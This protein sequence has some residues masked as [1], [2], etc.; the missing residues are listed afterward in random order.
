M[1]QILLG[2]F[3]Q[4]FVA[5]FAN[6]DQNVGFLG[7]PM[8]PLIPVIMWRKEG[9][10]IVIFIKSWAILR[11]R[12][13]GWICYSLGHYPVYKARLDQYL[14]HNIAWKIVSKWLT[15]YQMHTLD[16]EEW[17][18]PICLGIKSWLSCLSI[19]KKGKAITGS[20]I[21]RY[22]YLEWSEMDATWV[23]DNQQ[24]LV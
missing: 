15:Q 11:A 3:C 9:K 7:E 23:F 1:E 20:E 12:S 8:C 19:D 10:L 18:V 14:C 16:Y 5:W 6:T 2:N 21:K 22:H 17:K 4:I 24:N 13:W